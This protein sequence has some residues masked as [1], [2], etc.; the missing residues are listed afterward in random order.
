LLKWDPDPAKKQNIMMT[1]YYAL[2]IGLYQTFSGDSQHSEPGAISFRWNDR[3]N[4]RYSLGELCASLT[5]DYVRS[6]WGLVVCEPNWIYALC[7]TRG[8]SAL[9]VHDRM[10][11]TNFWEQVADGYFRGFG[12]EIIGPDGML[13]G[14]RSSRLGVG[15]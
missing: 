12:D 9:R 14:H 13:N 8:G 10:H 2:S 1:G 7:N 5:A 4:Y 6:P 15:K 3:R 11:G